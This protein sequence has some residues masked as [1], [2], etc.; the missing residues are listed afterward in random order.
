VDTPTNREEIVADLSLVLVTSLVPTEL[1][2][3][4]AMCRVFFENPERARPRTHG[5]EEVSGFGVGEAVVL[6]A[7]RPPP[8]RN[9]FPKHH[10]AV[11]NLS[12][13]QFEQV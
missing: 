7:H 5:G 4:N 3:L 12:A 13:P 6:L 1:P 11:P 10:D 2:S 9:G 8:A